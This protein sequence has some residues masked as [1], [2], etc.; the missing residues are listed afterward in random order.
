[1]KE[2]P[3]V[4]ILQTPQ[5]FRATSEQTWVERGAGSLQEIFYRFIQV[6]LSRTSALRPTADHVYV[7]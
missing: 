1:M 2:D 7:S 4:A 5:Y 6:S 3:R